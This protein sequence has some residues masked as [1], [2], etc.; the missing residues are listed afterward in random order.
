MTW[1]VLSHCS[2]SNTCP[3]HCINVWGDFSRRFIANFQSL[4]D[5]P[6]LPWDLKSIR[7]QNDETLRSFLKRFQTMRN[8]IPEVVEAAVIEDFYQGSNDS[9]FVRAILQKAPT[10]SEQLFR[11]VDIY[12]T[13]DE[14]ALDLIEGTKSALPVPRTSAGKKGPMRRCTLSGHLPLEPAVHLVEECGHWMK[15][16]TPSVCITRTCATPYRTAETSN[17]PSA[18]VDHSSH[19]HLPRHEESLASLGSLSN[20]KRGGVD[21]S[22]ALTRRSTSYLE[23]MGH[24]KTGGNKSSTIDRSWWPRP[25]LRPLTDGRNTR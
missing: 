17:T 10:T 12:I 18:M 1:E 25:V 16:S 15:S 4:S 21:L 5:K 19:Y 9:A 13:T 7:C 3:R 2:G 11:E 14:R 22:H 23:A 24:K 8:R 20:R 6:A